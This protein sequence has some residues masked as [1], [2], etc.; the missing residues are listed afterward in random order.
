MKSLPRSAKL[1]ARII[2]AD[3]SMLGYTD[4]GRRALGRWAGGAINVL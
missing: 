3:P 2:V 4:I 1:L